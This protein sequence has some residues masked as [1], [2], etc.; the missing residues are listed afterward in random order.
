MGATLTTYNMLDPLGRSITETDADRLSVLL[1]SMSFDVT[2]YEVVVSVNGLIVDASVDIPLIDSDFVAVMVIPRKGIVRTI[3]MVA[4]TILAS[5]VVGPA[6]ANFLGISSK[7]GTAM[8][9][10]FVTAGMSTLANAVL[11]PSTSDLQ[12]GSFADRSQTYGWDAAS[13]DVHEGD[14]LPWLAG[15]LVIKPKRISRYVETV[16]DSQYLHLLYAIHDGLLT[17]LTDVKINNN[18]IANYTGVSYDIRYGTVD[19]EPFGDFDKARYDQPIGA[20]LVSGADWVTYTT[21]GNMVTDLVFCFYFPYGLYKISDRDG[22]RDEQFYVSA[23]YSLDGNTWVDIVTDYEYSS[24]QGDAPEWAQKPFRRTLPVSGLSPK[25]YSV[26]FKGH[27]ASNGDYTR[28]AECWIDFMQE[29]SG[30]NFRFPGTS[31]LRVKALATGQLS[32][33]EPVVSCRATAGSNNPADVSLSAL[34]QCQV[35][36]SRID[37]ASFDEWRQDCIDRGFTCNI[38]VDATSSLRE[39]LDTVSTLGRARVEQ[40]GSRFVVIMDKPGILPTQGFLF[41]MGN[42]SRNSLEIEA[43]DV[44]DRANVIEYTYYPDDKD[45]SS[46]IRQVVSASYSTD[47]KERRTQI[48]LPGCTDHVM[49]KRHAQ[50]QLRCNRFLTLAPSWG[51]DAD[52]LVC[53]VGD[54]VQVAHDVP[55]WGYSGRLVSGSTAGVVLDREITMTEGVSYAVQVMY[56]AT[57]EVVVVPVVT[58]EGTT[59]AL[60]FQHAVEVAPEKY[61]NYSFGVINKTSKLVRLKSITTEGIAKTRKLVGLEYVPEIHEEDSDEVQTIITSDTGISQLRVS[62]YV[63]KLIDGSVG[64][65]LWIS[66]S[67]SDIR[68]T[69]QYKLSSVDFY[70]SV[71][72]YESKFEVPITEPGIYSVVISDSRG[73]IL[74]DTHNV[75]SI[76]IASTKTAN[77]YLYQWTTVEPSMPTGT[78]T[79]SWKE[80]TNADYTG[81]HGW[82]VTIPTNSGASG[83]RLWSASKMISAG[84]ASDSTIVDWTEGVSI[85]VYAVNGAAGSDGINGLQTAFPSVYQWDVTIPSAPVGDADY[86]WSTGTFGSPP[87]GWSLTPGTS[88][89]QG[90]T[91]WKATVTVIDSSEKVTT[92]FAWSN[93]SISPQGYVGVDGETGANGASARVCYARFATIV[94]PSGTVTTSGSTSFPASNA[95]GVSCAAGESWAASD[96][97]PSETNALFQANGV[98]SPVTGNTV[99]STPYLS[100]LKVGSL[101]A[102]TANL[103]TVNAGVLESSGYTAGSSGTYFDLNNGALSVFDSAGVLRVKIGN[104]A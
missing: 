39:F 27:R 40:F 33:T 48:K 50:Y 70:T 18:A 36:D 75:A 101:S 2:A 14:A 43:L 23:Q 56:S 9:S 4:V 84:V 1:S 102:I 94:T 15:S 72:V 46:E 88:P 63:R 52:A 41:G 59:D 55:R 51:A 29:V 37:S 78:T 13:N 21:D 95:W 30:D 103:G 35:S 76:V 100:S 67:G 53:R 83:L 42:I 66:W 86:A 60:I 77:L 104:L 99:W 12:D 16:D 92:Q 87:T 57:N 24:G 45:N 80:M 54:V 90:Y 49:A 73:N 7:F 22:I 71:V 93:A 58:M 91:L 20:N 3:A 38:Y 32:G 47:T 10:A 89:S 44:T 65:V 62:D 19:Q 25:S 85:G 5:T 17:S 96:P 81:E 61:D 34:S 6:A 69:V 11:P 82:S 31:L 79:F 28:N 74:S 68:Y 26:R 97:S 64:S 98:Y 8:V